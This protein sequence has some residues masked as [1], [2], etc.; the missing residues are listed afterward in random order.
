MFGFTFLNGDGI[1]ASGEIAHPVEEGGLQLEV[2]LHDGRFPRTSDSAMRWGSTPSYWP[3][4]ACW[5]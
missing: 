1:V 3:L 4:Q 2:L 5:S